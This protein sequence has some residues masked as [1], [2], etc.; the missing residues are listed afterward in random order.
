MAGTTPDSA[1]IHADTMVTAGVYLVARSAE[2]FALSP[3]TMIVVAGIGALTALF[4]ATIGLV[5]NDIKKVLAY[6][7]VSQLG[8]M[9]IGVGVGAY[10]SGVFHLM[11]HAFFKAL[12]FMGAGAVIHAMHHAYH[13]THSHA[14]A[15]DMRNM[16]GLRK[17]MKITWI[18]MWIATLAI[19]GVWPFAGFFSKDEIIWQT[20]ARATGV[21][22]PW[23]KIYWVMALAAAIM[24]AF[25]MTRLMVM[26][27]H[28]ANRTGEKERSH[29]HEVPL[30]MTV[31]LIIL[32]VLSVVGGWINV[33]HA[34]REIPVLGMI[35][36]G[37][38]LHEWLHPV[39]EQADG[40]LLA[41]TSALSH[42]SPLGGGEG[43]WAVTS[44]LLALAV[45]LAT[46]FMLRRREQPTAA[47]SPEP[48]G[49]RKVLYNKWYVD[50]IY[51][52]VVVRPV[53]S[54]SRGLW[55]I[56]DNGI[57]DGAVNG[58][59][60]ASRAMGWV[61]AQMQ[62]GQ[63]NTYAFAVVFGALLLL[64]FAFL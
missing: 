7:T 64:A 13:A 30:V 37:E 38:W 41:N 14:D 33:P 63:L 4:A 34:I 61:G 1:M 26:T 50:E 44:F 32:A 36:S 53:L 57:I 19:S 23:F 11:T 2:L 52:A 42:A 27:F 10:A 51:D 43:F 45:I 6:S 5:Q 56:V 54:V 35:P 39:M 9:F 15:Q 17:Y 48:A 31:P 8:Y 21:F 18:T 55:R 40:V 60:Y 25:Y 47:A 46:T 28:G 58:A 49:F 29:L 62:T 3:T 16:G 20:G 59:G 12:L 24:T 22:E